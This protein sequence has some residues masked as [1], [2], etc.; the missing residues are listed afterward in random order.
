MR[1]AGVARQ[2]RAC[3]AARCQTEW[4]RCDGRRWARRRP[5]AVLLLRLLLQVR[6]LRRRRA[7][8][9]ASSR[10]WS[11]R[12]VRCCRLQGLP[13]RRLVEQGARDWATQAGRD[14]VGLVLIFCISFPFYSHFVPIFCISFPFCSHF[15]PK[16]PSIYAKREGFYIMKCIKWCA[17]Q[18]I[19]EA[20]NRPQKE[21]KMD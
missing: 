16:L 6:R 10:S 8:S 18:S 13:R 3:R 19:F 7:G 5:P 14:F 21:L 1:K 12:A 4:R 15:I 17:L 9:G 11:C 2:G 20:G